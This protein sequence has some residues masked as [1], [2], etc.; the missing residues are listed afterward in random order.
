VGERT[1]YAPGT[2]CWVDL[3]T[4][5]PDG[6]KRFYGELLG[7]EAE[8]TPAGDVDTYTML[9]VDGKYVCALYEQP[10]EQR[11]QVPPSWMS[12]VSVEGVGASAARA[13]ELGGTVVQEPVDVMEAGRMALVQD[14]QG[15]V[16][17]L[18]EARDHFGAAL[19]N[20]PGAL[21]LNQLNAADVDAAREFY[22]GLFGWRIEPASEEGGAGYLGIHNGENLNGGMMALPPGAGAPPHWLVY[23]TTED[24]DVANGLIGE[25]GGRV[26]VEPTEVPAGRFLVAQDPQGA[27]FALFEG[28]V[29]P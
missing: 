19:V 3:A 4:P 9:R 6:A 24:M 21:T 26:L 16:F 28:E 18:W 10:R 7:W 12:Y 5:D 23:F 13:R 17:A 8:D 22:T 11:R 2:F 15:A 1:G 29:D 25:L 14:P 27:A 20:D